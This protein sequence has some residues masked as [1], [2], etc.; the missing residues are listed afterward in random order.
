MTH[1]WKKGFLYALATAGTVLLGTGA[2]AQS[3]SAADAP[4]KVATA[5]EGAGSAGHWDLLEQRCSKCHNSTDW[6][7]GIAFDTMTPRQHRRR[8]GNLGKGHPQTARPPDASARASSSRTR[9]P[10][11]PSWRWMERKLDQCRG[12]EPRPRLRGPASPEPHRIRARDR[13]TARPR[14]RREDA[15]AERRVER[16]LRQHRRGAAHLARVPGSVH[17]RRAQREP[18]GHRPRGR[19]TQHPRISASTPSNQSEH[20]DGLPLGTR[21]GMLVEHYFPAD[22][23][24]KFNIREFFFDGRG[25]RHEGR[26]SVTRS[27]SPST[28]CGC[29]NRRWA[30]PK[31]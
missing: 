21:G 18:P 23:E 8:S 24:Y 19:E 28:T 6:A 27:S 5:T 29:S 11:T 7:G 12:R 17:L 15:A 9:R 1:G 30:A 13:A 26:S 2:P 4:S 14:R 3:V 25:L 10:S 16:R 31:T 22:G 20:I